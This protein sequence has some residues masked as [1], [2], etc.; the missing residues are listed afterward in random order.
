M[1]EYESTVL[2]RLDWMPADRS[3][4][5]RIKVRSV[6][7]CQVNLRS[8]EAD[9]SHANAFRFGQL[10]SRLQLIQLSWLKKKKKIKNARLKVNCLRL[11]G[12]SPQ[13]QPGKPPEVNGFGLRV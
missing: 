3:R 13:P 5:G 4:Q 2:S 1:C 9:S 11:P 12:S 6:K 10:L 7:K 8:G